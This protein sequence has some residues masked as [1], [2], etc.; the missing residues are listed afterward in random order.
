MS[1]SPVAR[2]ALVEDQRPA[3]GFCRGARV[4]SAWDRVSDVRPARADRRAEIWFQPRDGSSERAS[5]ISASWLSTISSTSLECPARMLMATLGKPA[6][7]SSAS[8]AESRR[9]WKGRRRSAAGRRWW[10][11]AREPPAG[12]RCGAQQFLR[13]GAKNPAGF[14]KSQTA[15]GAGEQAGSPATPQG[16]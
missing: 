11:S 10:V 14:G 16:P 2:S 4:A 3:C 5:P 8:R 12:E 13:V 6:E 1:Q 15:A 7:I 9:K